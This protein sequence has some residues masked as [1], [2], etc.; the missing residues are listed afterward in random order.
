M[1]NNEENP[2]VKRTGRALELLAPGVYRLTTLKTA[3]TLEMGRD[4]AGRG[5]P[6]RKTL[7]AVDREAR[8]LLLKDAVTGR[9][10]R[11]EALTFCLAYDV[12][13]EAVVPKVRKPERRVPSRDEVEARLDRLEAAIAR[14]EASV[15]TTAQM[16]VRLADEL[17][18]KRG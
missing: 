16:L 15:T 6:H 5:R 3:Y 1:L 7:V 8:R 14:V 17:G 18:L 11:I 2:V 13:A 12:P 4:Y 10:S 9:N